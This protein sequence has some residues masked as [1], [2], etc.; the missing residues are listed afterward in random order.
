MPLDAGGRL[1]GE[2]AE[3]VGAVAPLARAPLPG[4][5]ASVRAS[6]RE[7]TLVLRSGLELRLGDGADWRSS[8]RSPRRILPATST[9]GAG[10]L[11]VGVP[12]RPVAGCNPRLSGRG[13]S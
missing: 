7:L 1:A 4:R 3:A 12:E 8:S 5:V 11:D 13:E 9:D 2:A 10:Y 6:D